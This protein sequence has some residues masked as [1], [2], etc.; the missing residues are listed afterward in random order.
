MDE[1]WR[2]L[3]TNSTKYVTCKA[4]YEG[5]P[6]QMA[7]ALWEWIQ[8]A[9][10]EHRQSAGHRGYTIALNNTLMETLCRELSVP[11]DDYR[12]WGM[13][14]GNNSQMGRQHIATA[15]YI[16]H[17]QADGIQVADYLLARLPDA[18]ADELDNLLI[19]NKSAWTVGIRAGRRGLTRRVIVGG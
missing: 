1:I 12:V 9:L 7:S 6:K 13:G 8:A 5:I 10:T 18:S 17:N 11:L 4:L 14:S 3:E 19:R 16:L 2:P 15:M